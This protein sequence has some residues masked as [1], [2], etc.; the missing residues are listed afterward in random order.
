MNRIILMLVMLTACGLGRQ[1]NYYSINPDG[2]R[3]ERYSHVNEYSAY[4][5]AGLGAQ[6]TVSD[7]YE[8]AQH[9]APPVLDVKIFNS[10]LPPGV[11]LSNGVV[12]I[13]KDAPYEAV[14]RFQIG[15]WLSSA[16]KE[17]EVKDDLVR[18]ASVTNTTV[19][20]VEVT[21]MSHADPHVNYLEGFVLREKPLA[22]LT[23]T[24]PL[25]PPT[26][27]H[28]RAKLA[29]E[30]RGH[31][32]LSMGEFSDEV[33]AVLGYSP[34]TADATREL[35]VRIAENAGAFKA[36]ITLP[37]APSKDVQGATCQT[38]TQAAVAV[39]AVALQE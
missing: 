37:H 1:P 33:S 25:P 5:T 16:P 23:A 7:S 34:W 21:H 12:Q 27:A 9:A 15:Y 2:T 30:A 10:S 20:V 38:A 26:K 17:T 6:Q 8:K 31:G 39:F 14:G 13:D 18:L 11:T 35:K 32:C 24:G 36:T 4:G 28:V 22:M 29:Y 3:S 19:V